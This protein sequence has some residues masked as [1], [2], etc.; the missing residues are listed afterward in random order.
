MVSSTDARSCIGR[1][2]Y[3]P[4]L[5]QRLGLAH[6]GGHGAAGVGARRCSAVALTGYARAGGGETLILLATLLWAVEVVLAKRLFRQP[7]AA[8]CR[9]DLYGLARRCCSAGRRQRPRRPARRPR[10]RAVD[11]GAACAHVATWNAALA[12][13]SAVDVTAV[14]VFGAVVTTPPWSPPGRQ[15]AG[16]DEDVR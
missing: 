2:W 9:P 3:V 4:L 15:G 1:C 12:C 14:L 6:I 13:A 8:H 7:A 16:E 5:G 10:R 11:R